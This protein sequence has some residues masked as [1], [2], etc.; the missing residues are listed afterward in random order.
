MSANNY[1]YG[2]VVV[3]DIKTTGSTKYGVR[4]HDVDG[5]QL[6]GLDGFPSFQVS[7]SGTQITLVDIKPFDAK[8]SIS[9]ATSKGLSAET[10]VIPERAGK[11]G[12]SI[13]HLIGICSIHAGRLADTTSGN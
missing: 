10:V 5:L 7:V 4:I 8:A 11:G 1:V 2:D 13:I 6:R 3:N 12:S 9:D